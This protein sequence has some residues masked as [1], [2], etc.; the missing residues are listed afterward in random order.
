MF[1]GLNALINADVGS[2]VTLPVGSFIWL[3]VTK[4]SKWQYEVE[5]TITYSRRF[6]APDIQYIPSALAEMVRICKDDVLGDISESVRK[7]DKKV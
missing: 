5:M 6:F 2:V 1:D 4:V 7:F 3:Q